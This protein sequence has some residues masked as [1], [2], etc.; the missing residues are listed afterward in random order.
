MATSPPL[1]RQRRCRC[2]SSGSR[3]MSS[4]APS[5]SEG[6]KAVIVIR[7]L[8]VPLPRLL[9]QACSATLEQ[10]ERRRR[11][12]R[13]GSTLC[14]RGPARL[15]RKRKPMSPRPWARNGPPG[16]PSGNQAQHG[17]AS[18]PA[19]MG[20]S[21]Q[22]ARRPRHRTNPRRSCARPA[23]PA[24]PARLRC[25]RHRARR[26]GDRLALH[27]LIASVAIA[28]PMPPQVGHHTGRQKRARPG[29][30]PMRQHG[31]IT[32]GASAATAPA[33]PG[34][35]TVQRLLPY[36]RQYPG[37]VAAAMAFIV[38]ANLANVGVPVLLKTLVDAM[39]IA[40]GAPA[41]L[42]VVPVGLL[43]AYGGLRLCTSLCTELRELVL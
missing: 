20:T 4:R 26:P 19:P 41:A 36:L 6:G 28:S 10:S 25:Q 35:A 23:R 11:R 31:E 33:P 13:P 17:P 15:G 5:G 14:E 34:R 37:R 7:P 40:P 3:P 38:G 24:R 12:E 27:G 9:H 21:T 2:P 39:A 16:P 22:S 18:I 43:L 29:T 1:A 32:P 30:N 42:L 8:R